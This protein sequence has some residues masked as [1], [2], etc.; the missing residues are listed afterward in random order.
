MRAI[1]THIHFSTEQGHVIKDK[2]LIEAMEK[3]YRMKV[4]Y[5]TEEGMAKKYTFSGATYFERM[6]E[7]GTYTTDIEAIQRRVEAAG[8][9]NFFAQEVG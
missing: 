3:Y 9:K 4:V 2:T 6:K 8:F 1:D 7:L 5:K